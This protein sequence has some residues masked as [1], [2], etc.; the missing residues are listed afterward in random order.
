MEY[1]T[2]NGVDSPQIS[3]N[4]AYIGATALKTKDDQTAAGVKTF[5]SIPVLPGA[6]TTDNQLANKKYIDDLA[7]LIP[8]YTL[9]ASDYL[10]DS[11]NTLDETQNTSPN[12]EK[13]LTLN[14]ASGTIRVKFYLQSK[15]GD[16]NANAQIYVN[17]SAVGT[18]RSTKSTG[19]DAEADWE[20]YSED[21]SVSTGDKIQL[22]LWRTNDGYTDTARCKNFRLY[23]S[24]SITPI[25]GTVNL[26]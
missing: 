1:H 23:Y 6:P 26:N 11:L 14:E 8:D 25:A 2:H 24:R 7:D 10:V 21:I 19:S 17:G 15:N 9:V 4:G 18:G 13:E 12:K 22:Y 20:K 3:V 5:S 16:E